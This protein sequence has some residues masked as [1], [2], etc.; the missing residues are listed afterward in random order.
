MLLFTFSV[1][2]GLFTEGTKKF[3]NDKDNFS[4]NLIALCIALI[5]GIV[6]TWIYYQLNNIAIDTNIDVNVDTNVEIDINES[7]DVK[8]LDTD[9]DVLDN[10]DISELDTVDDDGIISETNLDSEGLLRNLFANIDG[11]DSIVKVAEEID[12][13]VQ[14]NPDVVDKILNDSSISIQS[15]VAVIVKCQHTTV[16]EIVQQLIDFDVKQDFFKYVLADYF[17]GKGGNNIGFYT[18]LQESGMGILDYIKRIYSNTSDVMDVL[19]N[20]SDG[21]S[22]LKVAIDG[23]VK[24]SSESITQMGL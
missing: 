8:N 24:I 12:N 3:I 23:E 19:R 9:T 20:I 10:G 13:L 15:K 17:S 11:F 22:I 18:L 7:G 2:S 1:I 5:V 6:G 4:Y 16:K 21:N 14:T